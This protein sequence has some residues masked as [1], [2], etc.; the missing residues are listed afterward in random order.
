VRHHIESPDPNDHLLER[1]LSRPNMRLAWKR[2]RSNKGV[3]GVDGLS[4]KAFP[5]VIH[6]KWEN[7]R[8]S[9]M[10]GTYDLLPVL[11]VEILKPTGEPVPW[12][13][14]PYRTD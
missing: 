2:A 5:D 14:R 12:G 4:I 7:I 13:Y 8:E 10:E 11:R 6:D 3:A 1:I 9:L